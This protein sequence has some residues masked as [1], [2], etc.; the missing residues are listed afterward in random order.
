MNENLNNSHTRTVKHTYS[1]I[2]LKKTQVKV[3]CI[4]DIFLQQNCVVV[5]TKWWW[6]QNA[7]K[8]RLRKSSSSSFR[9]PSSLSMVVVA[10]LKRNFVIRFLTILLATKKINF[11]H[12]SLI[13]FD[14]ISFF[15]EKKILLNNHQLIEKIEKRTSFH[16]QLYRVYVCVPGAIYRERKNKNHIHHICEMKNLVKFCCC[17][18][19]CESNQSFSFFFFVPNENHNFISFFFHYFGRK[20]FYEKFDNEKKT[21]YEIGYYYYFFL[22]IMCYMM[23]K[24]GSFIHFFSLTFFSRKKL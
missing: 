14:W 20:I 4:F 3:N 15:Y 19:V 5:T 9:R 16:F 23:M 18:F 12:F 10:F 1:Y 8:K 7:K 11:F 17:C 24:V 6:Q 13:W 21:S 2:Q 22:T